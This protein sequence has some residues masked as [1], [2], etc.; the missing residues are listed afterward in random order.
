MKPLNLVLTNAYFNMTGEPG[1]MFEIRKPS[2]WILSRLFNK[3]GSVKNYTHVELCDGYKKNRSTKFREFKG[4]SIASH[5]MSIGIP[6]GEI[7]TISK[8]D[9]IIR[10]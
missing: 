4:F 7:L 10:L 2:K 9:I 8:G 5:E 3:D 1:K 6:N